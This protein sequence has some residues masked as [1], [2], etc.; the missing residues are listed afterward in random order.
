MR[1]INFLF[2]FVLFLVITIGLFGIFIISHELFHYY[3]NGNA[4]GI[5]FGICPAIVNDSATSSLGAYYFIQDKELDMSLQE[6]NAY[7]FCSIFTFVVF[8]SLIFLNKLRE[9]E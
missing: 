7:I 6:R 4:K 9:H 3:S 8:I 1:I 5:C 2:Y